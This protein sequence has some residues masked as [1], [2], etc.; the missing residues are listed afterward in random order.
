MKRFKMVEDDKCDFCG[1]VENAK[2]LMWDCYRARKAWEFLQ[3]VFDTMDIGN[4]ISFSSIIIG[5]SPTL[6]IPESLI[7]VTMRQIV[8]RDRSSAII[9]QSLKA[10]LI[11]H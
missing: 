6:Q 4:N 7:T 2:H 1:R 10:R 5:F 9:L 8:A 11:E 3:R